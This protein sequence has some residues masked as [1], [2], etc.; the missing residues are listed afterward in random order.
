MSLLYNLGLETHIA[1]KLFN[2]QIKLAPDQ[3]YYAMCTSNFREHETNIC[4]RCHDNMVVDSDNYTERKRNIERRAGRRIDAPESG[5]AAGVSKGYHRG[6]PMSSLP[7]TSTN[8][9]SPF[10]SVK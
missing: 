6:P 8:V 9:T 1:Q 5:L 10:V 3:A 4:S 7:G 2:A